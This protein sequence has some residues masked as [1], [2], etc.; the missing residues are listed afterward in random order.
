MREKVMLGMSGGVDSSVAAVLL[1]EQGYDVV[2][3]TLKLRPDEYMTESLS[4]GCC[5]LDDISDAKRVADALCIPHYVLGFTDIFATS[6]IDYFVAEYKKGRTP[7]PCI[8]CNRYVKFGAMLKKALGMG[9][10]SI[11]TG[12]Y[13]VIEREESGRFLLRRSFGKKDQSYALYTMTQHE[14]A[15]TLFPLGD[16]DKAEAR[17]I[18]QRNGLPVA[19]KPDSQEICFVEDNNYAHFIEK[20]TGEISLPGD[21]IDRQ[22]RPIGRHKGMTHYTIGQR[23]GLGAAFG[24]PMYV[25]RLDT[26]TNQITLGEEGSQYASALVAGDINWIAF[27]QLHEERAVLAKVR[28]QAEPVPAYILPMEGQQVAVRFD[29]PQR[30]VTPGQAVVFYDDNYVLGGGTIL[31]TTGI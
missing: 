29:A 5:S 26:D 16:M 17:D 3:V 23:K 24:K 13:A 20:Y 1:L 2:G 15:H 12:H 14:L 27:D 9:M 19:N 10:D 18:A 11:A 25:T 7:N 8:A 6:V 21:F 22:G 31:K 4:G 28:Y 30:A